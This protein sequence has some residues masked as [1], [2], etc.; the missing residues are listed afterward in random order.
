MGASDQ[1]QSPE[2]AG[3]SAPATCNEHGSRPGEDIWVFALATAQRQVRP[4]T[5]PAVPH[6]SGA[7]L[8]LVCKAS[9]RRRSRQAVQAGKGAGP[10]RLT[11]G[12]QSIGIGHRA[13]L[14]L[15]G[16]LAVH[17][18]VAPVAGRHGHDGCRE[19]RM[20]GEGRVRGVAL[21]QAQVCAGPPRRTA[22]Q[23]PPSI[24]HTGTSPGRSSMP[25]IPHQST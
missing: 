25:L 4:N 24:S 10:H 23:V 11:A 15:Q 21:E 20:A 8:A 12:S 9:C 2:P 5:L 6:H 1:A 7:A 19:A 18:A 14:S 3:P 22:T 16:P 17:Q 13:S